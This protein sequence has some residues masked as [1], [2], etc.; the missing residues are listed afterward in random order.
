MQDV[1][2]SIRGRVSLNAEALNMTESVGNYVKHRRV[3]IMIREDD[4]SYAI[5]FTP[6]ISGESIAHGLQATIAEKAQETNPPQPVC[7]LCKKQIF[8]KSS[9]KQI[10]KEAFDAEIDEESIE[11]TIIS[12][13]IVED[14]GGF[15]YAEKTN[16][17]RTSNFYTGYMIPTYESLRNVV[18]E[19]QLHS[20]YALGTK[21]VKDQ[22]QMLYYVEV[23]SSIYTFSL[24]IDTRYIGKLT[25][26][27]ENAGKQVINNSEKLERV[28]I[29]LD[30]VES[31]LVENRYGAKKTRFLPLA[32][33]ESMAIAVSDRIWTIPSPFTNDYLKRAEEK[34]EKIN[35]GTRLYSFEKG[36]FEKFIAEAI[37]EIKSRIESS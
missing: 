35:H 16:V 14:I 3:P 1:F 28:K 20:R 2:I 33:W 15:L 17:K 7:K 21:F 36:S 32:E 4:G 24:D 6:A 5:Y 37:E 26:N 23:S 22:G 13:C 9:N 8:L 30:A 25:F 34:R 19:P 18:I 29:L 10:V 27:I 12:R 31:F 11:E